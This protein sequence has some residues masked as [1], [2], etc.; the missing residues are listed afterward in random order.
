MSAANVRTITISENQSLSSIFT[1]AHSGDVPVG[2]QFVGTTNI[3][4]IR[5]RFSGSPGDYSTLPVYTGINDIDYVD[6]TTVPFVDVLNG[7][8]VSQMLG[9]LISFQA[10]QIETLNSGGTPIA[11]T[12]GLTVRLI[13][14]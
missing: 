12:A 4:K 9:Q 7:I 6:G 5:M 2:V 8:E 14:F 13:F 3:D 11:V 1:L 10:L